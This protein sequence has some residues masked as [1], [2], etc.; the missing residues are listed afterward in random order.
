MGLK[1]IMVVDDEPDMI[2]VLREFLEGEGYT[3]IPANNGKEALEKF[4]QES[5]DLVLLDLAMPIMHGLDV[6][7][8]LKEK[9]KDIAVIMIT[10]YRDAEKVVDAFRLG[11]YDCIF[12]PF[13]F[14]YLKKCIKAKI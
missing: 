9:K 6:L 10:A 2:E 14:E 5:P 12:K 8:E 3:V 13:D 11:A 7:Q 4:D 1:K